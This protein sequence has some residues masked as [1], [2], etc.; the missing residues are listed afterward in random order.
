METVPLSDEYWMSS[1][2][3]KQCGE[4]EK[5][6][7]PFRRKHH[8]RF[9]GQIFCYY[10]CNFK[11]PTTDYQDH[12]C[13]SRCYRRFSVN[14]V[15]TATVENTK[16]EVVY[17]RFNSVQFGQKDVESAASGRLVRCMTSRNEFTLSNGTDFIQAKVQELL[18]NY[19][20]DRSWKQLVIS[21]SM[22]VVHNVW[23]SVRYREDSPNINQY[24]RVICA[25]LA[26]PSQSFSIDGVAFFKNVAHKRM[27]TQIA[28]PRIL[29]F[30]GSAEFCSAEAKLVSMDTVIG[31]EFE[32]NQLLVKK[33][34][35][36]N[37]N[38][39]IIER[40]MSQTVL[41]EL[42]QKKITVILN[43]KPALL[44]MI[45]RCTQAQVL[46]S[47]N[48]I[49]GIFNPIGNCEVFEVIK[50]GKRSLCV[51][52]GCPDPSLGSTVVLAGPTKPEL[53]LLKAVFKNLLTEYRTYLLELN[54]VTQF[55]LVISPT[56]TS[57]ALFHKLT[58][59]NNK[60]CCSPERLEVDFYS[61]SDMPLGKF[62]LLNVSKAENQCICDNAMQA[63]TTVY[64]CYGGQVKV[65]IEM[66]KEAY[67]AGPDIVL[68]RTCR[69]CGSCSASTLTE[70]S[71]EFSFYHFMHMMMHNTSESICGH[72]FFQDSI[73]VLDVSGNRVSFEWQETIVFELAPFTPK[74]KAFYGDV[75]AS[76]SHEL[77]EKSTAALHDLLSL[78][79]S[80][81]VS[82]LEGMNA[83]PEELKSRWEEPKKESS[84]LYEQCSKLLNYWA[85]YSFSGACT[86]MEIE[87]KRRSFFLELCD[88]KLSLQKL[89]ANINGIFSSCSSGIFSVLSQPLELIRAIGSSINYS[90]SRAES[91]IQEDHDSSPMTDKSSEIEFEYFRRGN[92]TL[93]LGTHSTCIPVEE[94]D[95][96]TMIAYAL[97]SEEYNETIVQKT[98]PDSSEGLTES[99][100]LSDSENHCSIEVVS[101]DPNMM[102]DTSTYLNTSHSIYGDE[103]KL[104]VTC[105]FASQFQ[106]LRN[107][108]LGPHRVFL[109]SILRSSVEMKKLGKS[110]A[111]F[112]LSHDKRFLLKL[113]T[114][115]K[116]VSMFIEMAPNY[117]RHICKNLFHNMPS[118]L[119]PT[120]GVYKISFKNIT[121]H[122]EQ[123]Y[124][125]IIQDNIGYGLSEPCCVYDLK[126]TLNSNRYVKKGDSRTKMDLNFIE[127][128]F[129]IPIIV[130]E[131]EKRML[132]AAFHNDSLFLSKQN[133]M[134][135][136]MLMIY[137]LGE[138]KLS[139][140]VI[141]YSGQYTLEKLIESHFKRAVKQDIP[142]VISPD[143]YKNRFRQHMS[144]TFLLGLSESK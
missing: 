93:P 112:L 29:I 76:M 11:L 85:K 127:D 96:F 83:S 137:N 89:S 135:Y 80:L 118:R 32:Y 73:I 99:L 53:K 28:K 69:A 91:F 100:L 121:T 139:A 48:Q 63:H 107:Y 92:L 27:Q 144:M 51:L 75:I 15:H 97:N 131:D 54:F 33:V 5:Y 59:C 109:E 115:H 74:L 98:N 58:N 104:K 103:V 55:S 24:V 2:S 101:H 18:D 133:V 46:S 60:P 65:T 36:A 105:Y 56:R 49:S 88:Y 6:F 16:E 61:D 128:H 87:S 12:K 140:A 122:S 17:K 82:V 22:Q 136:S 126:G 57:S 14:E 20:L 86:I 125:A 25:D 102:A 117:F 23:P 94:D 106:A 114:D 45:A 38:L 120:Y 52:R 119:A 26:I 130:R 68:E 47:I 110:R 30:E 7:H 31:L 116:E 42:K 66:L 13:C 138:H 143:E 142:T 141:D 67:E 113:L 37:P 34:L 95:V 8:C 124:W 40:G 41:N 84:K 21:H 79:N 19:E 129:G 72:R 70:I 134:D 35:S 44:K 123:T 43:V 77:K 64:I 81:K 90:Q 62:C 111:S 10:C 3:A 4:C 78:A 39:L 71:W 132:D 1:A 108:R 9:C 50:Y